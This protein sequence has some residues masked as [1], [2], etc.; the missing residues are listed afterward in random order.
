MKKLHIP[1]QL[2]LVLIFVAFSKS[3]NAQQDPNF[4]QY[5]YNTMTINPAYA[6][7]RDVW[8]TGML[9]RSQWTGIDGAPMTGTFSTHSP[10]A[11]SKMGL[12][13]NIVHD[14]IGPAENTFMNVNYSYILQVSRFTKLSMGLSG[15]LHF[16][17]INF[18]RLN[19]FDPTDPNFD[20]VRNRI[21][22][23]VG[24]GLQLYNDRYFVGL[25]AP[26]VLRSTQFEDGGGN[27]RIREEIHYY[28]TAGYVFDLNPD[29]Q[30]KPSILT[31]AVRGAPLRVDLSANFLMYEK[32][33]LGAA[34]RWD[35]AISAMV[36]IQATDAL[37]IGFAYDYDTV[38]FAEFQNASFEV[39][40]RYELFKK[41]KKMYTPR[42]F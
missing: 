15:G 21:F 26:F 25:S 13:L 20:N 30:F 41:Y 33:T 34:Y 9:Y 28:L 12:G 19:I 10:L 40:L 14:A 6:G 7:T 23:Q 11:D 38:E 39:F 4:T 32:F 29:L 31:R 27:G 17:N 24:A 36:G 8:S 16:E 2:V 42:F 3:T 22:P 37:L 35:A 1:Y 18:N 5:M